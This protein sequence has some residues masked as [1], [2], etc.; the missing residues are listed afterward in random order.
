MH[1]TLISK[2]FLVLSLMA[3]SVGCRGGGLGIDDITPGGGEGGVGGEGGGAGSEGGEGGGNACDVAQPVTLD[4]PQPGML[5]FD[6]E[7]SGWTV[8]ANAAFDTERNNYIYENTDIYGTPDTISGGV[9]RMARGGFLGGNG[10]GGETVSLWTWNHNGMWDQLAETTTGD[11]NPT[12]FYRFDLTGETAFG[13]G[14]HTV[15]SVLHADGTC[16]PHGVFSW[17]EG[18]QFIITD[19]DGTMTLADAELT[20]QIGDTSYVQQTNEGASELLQAWA[21]KGYKVVYLT[22]RPHSF[23]LLTRK[24]L[25]LKNMPY[26]PV[27]TASSLVFGPSARDY[28]AESIRQMVE[29]FGW[30]MVAA[31]GNAGSDIE[32]YEAASHAKDR[33]FIIG[34][35]A[36]QAGTVAVPD[37]SFLQHTSSYVSDQPEA[38]QPAG[39]VQEPFCR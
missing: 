6:V 20:R 37:Q 26:G 33:T 4:C 16:A 19:I 22:A 23:R 7:V 13:T 3:L 11:E 10:L 39:L 32:A 8:E 29:D 5:P 31:Y 2:T 38:T 1:K 35:N 28:K 12:G 17:P 14:D 9:G 36:G 30:E 18:T 27:I 15:Y 25:E 34:E 24:W 21:A